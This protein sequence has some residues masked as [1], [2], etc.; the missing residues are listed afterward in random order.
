MSLTQY[1]LHPEHVWLEI[2]RQ[3]ELSTSPPAGLH[4]AVQTCTD[5]NQICEAVILPYMHE[6]LPHV[7]RFN[8]QD[9]LWSLG[10]N[11]IGLESDQVR[12]V[13]LCS[14]AWDLDALQVPQEWV[15]IPDFVADYY[16][17]VQVD[18]EDAWVRLWGGTTHKT[19]KEQGH[20]NAGRR[21]YTLERSF[22]TEALSSIWLQQK[23]FPQTAR[24]G[25]VLPLVAPNLDQLTQAWDTMNAPLSLLALRQ[26]AF[27]VWASILTRPEWRQRAIAHLNPTH[28]FSPDPIVQLSQWFD[29]QF[30]QGW[31]AIN[32]LINPE[33]VGAFMDTQ[34]KRAKLIDLGVELLGCQVTLMMTVSATEQGMS[35]QASVYPTGEQLVLPPNLQLQILDEAGNIFKAVTSRSDDE[36]IRY[37]FDAEM[38]D[39]FTIQVVLGS[40]CIAEQFQI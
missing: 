3:L 28:Q 25:E 33:L 31:Q 4:P 18:L 29:H 14:E 12:L 36:F 23:H 32:Q 38:G 10:L 13:F 19:L 8:L 21:T 17:A 7:S 6:F 40:A 27:P 1:D 39:R 9:E 11:G 15:D 22:L 37:R 34:I 16:V 35:V 26:I 2:P 30:E 5:L 24:R 20:F